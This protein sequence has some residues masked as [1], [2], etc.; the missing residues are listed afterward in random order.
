MSY[1]TS[2]VSFGLYHDMLFDFLQ[3]LKNER[4]TVLSA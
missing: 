2:L 4:K 1:R 3:A